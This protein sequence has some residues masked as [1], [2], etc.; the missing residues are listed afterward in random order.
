MIKRLQDQGIIL[1][2]WIAQRKNYHDYE[3]ITHIYSCDSACTI[4]SMDRTLKEIDTL[5]CEGCGRQ[6][7]V[8][9]HDY[10]KEK[11]NE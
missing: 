5:Y 3:S 2:T 1:S 10:T 9:L 11:T 8:L 4:L 7:F 6:G